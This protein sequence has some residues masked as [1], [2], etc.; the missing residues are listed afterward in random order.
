MTKK[1]AYNEIKCK[2]IISRKH[3]EDVPTMSY[4]WR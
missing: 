4:D 2:K 1:K 3:K